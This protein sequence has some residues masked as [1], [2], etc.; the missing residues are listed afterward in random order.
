[1]AGSPQGAPNRQQGT[2]FPSHL[3]TWSI[4]GIFCPWPP[5]VSLQIGGLAPGLSGQAPAGPGSLPS[6]S[7]GVSRSLT[8]AFEDCH[9]PGRGG[10]L[11][12]VPLLYPP[13][14]RGSPNSRLGTGGRGSADHP[15][16]GKQAG[17][18]HEFLQDP[19]PAPQKPGGCSPH[20][21]GMHSAETCGGQA[22]G[23]SGH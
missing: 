13:F 5:L 12:F 11:F 21:P 7:P 18:N 1:M 3:P 4:L 2:E 9:L 23:H 15:L 8:A 20:S 10:C 14:L 16:G 22:R 17:T 6:L 19:E